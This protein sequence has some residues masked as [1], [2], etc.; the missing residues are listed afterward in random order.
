MNKEVNSTAQ[1]SILQVLPR[2]ESGG[3]ERGTLEIAKAAKEDGMK[4][5][6]ASAGGKLVAQL[7]GMSVEHITLPLDSK[8]PIVM[9]QNISKLKDII[10]KHNIEVVHARSRAPAWSAYFATKGTKAHFITTFHGVYGHGWFFK[11]LYNSVMFRGEVVIAISKFI[12]EHLQRVYRVKEEKIRLVYRGVDMDYFDPEKVST[13]RVDF[14]RQKWHLRDCWP[15]VVMP[16]RVTR[17]KGHHLLI[18]ALSQLPKGMQFYCIMVGNI[19][20]HE[21]YFD[22]LNQEVDR[23]NLSDHVKMVSSE[24]DM[25]AVYAL[26]DVVVSASVRPEAFGRVAVEAQAMGKPIIATDLGGSKETI[27]H[28]KTGRLVDFM[29]SREMAKAIERALYLSEENKQNI[30]ST[31]RQHVEENFSMRQMCDKTLA[32]YR[33]VAGYE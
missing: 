30:A 9:F 7:E 23:N 5:M 24:N 8:N 13:E 1:P 28:E 25:P 31:N 22:E 29:Y 21:H 33:K 14:L 16:A 17:W 4:S 10:K 20:G 2:L 12:S 6:V 11:R 27:I 3:V 15:I 26:A 19:T 32:I 18:S